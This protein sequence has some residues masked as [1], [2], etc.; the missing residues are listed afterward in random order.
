MKSNN[1]CIV[2]YKKRIIIKKQLGK[3]MLTSFDEIINLNI[4]VDSKIDIGELNGNKCFV[5]EIYEDIDLSEDY[6]F[7]DLKTLGLFLGEDMFYFIGRAYQLLEFE[8]QYKFCTRCG[9]ELINSQEERAKICTKCGL[10]H[11]PRISPAIIVAVTKQDKLLLAHNN[12]FEE[13][14]FSL[15]AGY[16]E[17]GETLEECVKREVYEEVGIKIKD[18]EYVTSQPWPVAGSLM[19][20]FQAKYQSGDIKVDGVEIGEANWY[21]KDKFPKLPAKI[22]VARKLIDK[23]IVS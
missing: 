17:V 18:I 22:S 13:G 15:I 2:F 3:Y 7:V 9:T 16:V 6:I 12:N 14:L 23:F 11:Y 4:K 5:L 19:L 10:I 1:I 8:N 21:S 20:A